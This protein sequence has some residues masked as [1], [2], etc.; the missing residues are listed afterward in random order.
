MAFGKPIIEAIYGGCSNFI[1]NNGVGYACFSD[2]YNA[3][4]TLIKELDLDE[5]KIIGIHSKEV[6]FMKYKR[7]V[8]VNK[9]MLKIKYLQE[10]Y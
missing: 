1:I 9:T 6:Y 5:L 8:F 4:A 10:I 3:L 2:D 7:S